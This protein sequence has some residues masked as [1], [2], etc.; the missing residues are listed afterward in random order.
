MWDGLLWTDLF[1]FLARTDKTFAVRRERNI[2]DLTQLI[3][4]LV[5]WIGTQ[6]SVSGSVTTV[7]FRFRQKVRY[8]LIIAINCIL[9]N[10]PAHFWIAFPFY[11]Y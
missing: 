9:S 2:P 5:V 10:R 7:P 8:V 6:K 1:T 4:A 11:S 3:F